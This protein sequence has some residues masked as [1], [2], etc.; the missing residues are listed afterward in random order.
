MIS[1]KAILPYL[2]CL[3]YLASPLL[4]LGLKPN[5]KAL[6]ARAAPYQTRILDTG[7]T[8][9]EEDNGVWQLIE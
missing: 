7:S 3:S 8:F 9:R 1:S 5:W 2:G 6:S 4:G